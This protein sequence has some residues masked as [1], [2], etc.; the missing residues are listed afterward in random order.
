MVIFGFSK[1]ITALS[2]LSLASAKSTDGTEK[3]D[4]CVMGAGPSGI[5]SAYE[6]EK[7]NLSVKV[8]EKT[9]Y[10][11]GKTKATWLHDKEYF[12]GAVLF[13]EN[14]YPETKKL[15]EAFEIKRQPLEVETKLFLGGYKFDL[16]PPTPETVAA[17]QKYAVIRFGLNDVL[18]SADAL[19]KGK[20]PQELNGPLDQWL[21]EN[22]L[23]ALGTYFWLI[24]T[25]FGYGLIS[26]TP[27]VYY[28]RYM[29]AT[30]FKAVLEGTCNIISYQQLFQKMAG[31]LKNPVEL[32]VTIDEVKYQDELNRVYYN[33][34]REAHCGKIV[35]AFPPTAKNM[36]NFTPD[37]SHLSVFEKVKT[38]AY[39]SGLFEPTDNQHFDK[40][41]AFY[42]HVPQASL[43][44]PF[45]PIFYY[46]RF[47]G[48]ETSQTAYLLRNVAIDNDAQIEQEMRNGM[49]LLWPVTNGTKLA[50]LKDLEAWDYFPHAD[51]DTLN[52]GFYQKFDVLQGQYNQYYVGC[53]FGFEIVEDA[54]AHAQYMIRK[55]I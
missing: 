7:Q 9:N 49:N 27:A 10:I 2:M 44:D 26:D 34:G 29:D 3:Y 22:H 39:Y 33:N 8:F 37:K 30:F 51:T 6:A 24:G 41:P 12:M 54:I 21:E 17:I 13:E 15:L 28:L 38:R 45:V 47:D 23:T 1:S 31:K 42:Y 53:T 20:Y 25:T 32:N 5:T 43:P 4:I 36:K 18:N 55:R 35:I 40:A 50:K 16:P 14:R 46:K 11:G 52:D 48:I 19:T